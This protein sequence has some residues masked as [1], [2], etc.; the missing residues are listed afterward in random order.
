MGLALIV[1][2]LLV[3][4]SFVYVFRYRGVVRYEGV[5]EYVRKGWPIFA[6]LNCLLYLFTQRR[7][8][9]VFMDLAE[10]PELAEIQKNW[11]VIRAEGLRLYEQGYFNKTTDPKSG[12]YFD[13]G[14]RTFYKYGWSKFYLKWYGHTHASAQVLCPGTVKIVSKIK[15]VNGAMFSVLPPGSQLTRHLDPLAV[16]LRYHLGLS[17]PNSDDC[18]INVDGQ[19]YSWRDGQAA[20]FDITYLHFARNETN[21]PRLILMCD[22]ERPLNL[23]GSLVNFFYRGLA[24]L[25]VVPNLEGD[26]RG[27]ANRVFA[28]VAPVLARSKELKKTNRSLYKLVK[29]AFNA[30][31]LLIVAAIL[32]GLYRLGR[33]AFLT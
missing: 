31:L 10:F 7:G 9:R 12:A 30:V 26:H 2:A 17:T 11:E 23:V 13:V 21:T 24:S 4:A 14:F 6:P 18:F 16:S 28:S 32:Y 29:F 19:R 1:A 20:L 33:Y 5:R 3:L 15:S 22:V 27:F 8:R 25:T